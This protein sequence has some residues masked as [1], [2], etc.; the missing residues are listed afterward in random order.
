MTNTVDARVIEVID[1]EEVELEQINRSLMVLSNKMTDIYNELHPALKPL[2]DEEI[3]VGTDVTHQY[4][5]IALITLG[6]CMLTSIFLLIFTK[7]SL[8]AS[9]NSIYNFEPYQFR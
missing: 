1:S 4:I 3:D 7:P 6:V 8:D 2:Y 5:Y 9:I